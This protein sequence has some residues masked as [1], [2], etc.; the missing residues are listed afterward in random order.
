MG[1]KT[2]TDESRGFP[3]FRSEM[4]KD[5]AKAKGFQRVYGAIFNEITWHGAIA[6][7]NFLDAAREAFKDTLLDK[8]TGELSS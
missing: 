7:S 6:M 1:S 5:F 4:I 8:S 3:R 2:N